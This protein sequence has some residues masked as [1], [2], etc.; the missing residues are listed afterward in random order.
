MIRVSSGH[1]HYRHLKDHYIF[2]PVAVET[3]GVWGKE[4]FN[5]IKKIGSKIT[6]VMGGKRST[7]YLFQR[8]SIH[9]QRSNAACVLGTLPPGKKLDE[10]FF[11]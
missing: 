5:L 3:T 6:G 1:H 9:I 4:G 7:N 2:I 11:L 10:I 8:L